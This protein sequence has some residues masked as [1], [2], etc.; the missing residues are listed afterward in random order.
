MNC[1]VSVII[2]VFNGASFIARSVQSALDQTHRPHEVIVINDGS[3]DR[4]L[5][6]L[7]GFGN[8]IR[9]ISIPNG[10]VSNA[11]NLGMQASSGDL[12]AFLDADDIWNSNKL[13]AQITALRAHPHVGFC[14]CDFLVYS[15][16]AGAVVNHFAQF[17]T[18]SDLAFDQPLAAPFAA[19]IKLN[20]VGTASN[21]MITRALMQKVGLFNVAYRQAEDYEYWLRCAQYTQF[22]LLSAALLE[23]RTHD[24][25]LTNNSLET[26]LCH[27]QVLLA[28]ETEHAASIA[29]GAC[30]PDAL[31]RIRY[32]IAHQLYIRGA[33]SQ[34][35][36]Y[37]LA[38]LRSH[39]SLGNACMFSYLVGR[40][41]LRFASFGLL[42]GRGLPSAKSP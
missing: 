29:R 16:R 2:P 9:V 34:A 41:L 21:V 39:K 4:T 37:Y 6:A 31:A 40:K 8:R 11:R 36:A 33:T 13:A 19:L 27:E 12:I 30:L 14:C 5:A 25:N 28:L 42:R 22:L 3:T 15:E 24:S 20:F 18:T 26:F 32:E 17:R 1:T 10:G 38:G 7:A 35:L 23:K